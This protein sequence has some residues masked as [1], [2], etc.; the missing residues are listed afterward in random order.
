MHLQVVNAL[1]T[2]LD[3]LK[4]RKNCLVM[5]TS[6]L[7]GAIDNA[8]IDRADIKQYIG[9]CVEPSFFCR[10]SERLPLIVT[11]V[12][13]SSWFRTDHPPLPSTGSCRAA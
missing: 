4:S 6:N 1:L 12:A 2:Q 9:L 10:R 3:K 8:F 13:Y 7:S 5:T 11:D